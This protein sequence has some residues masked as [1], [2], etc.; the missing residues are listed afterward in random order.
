[1]AWRWICNYFVKQS[2]INTLTE[3][4]KFMV[5]IMIIKIKLT[6]LD[7]VQVITLGTSQ[8]TRFYRLQ[9]RSLLNFIGYLTY[10]AISHTISVNY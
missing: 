6:E 4:I 9:Q 7:K 3:Q 5:M 2:Y 1:M 10:Y 8:E